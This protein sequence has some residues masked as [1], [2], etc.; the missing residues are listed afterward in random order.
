M[1]R[2]ATEYVEHSRLYQFRLWGWDKCYLILYLIE[3]TAR[4]REYTLHPLAFQ[5]STSALVAT[6]HVI[7]LVIIQRVV[8]S[9]AVT[10]ATPLAPIWFL[11]NV[12]HNKLNS[13]PLDK[14]T[15]ISQ[16]IISDAY[17]WMK[18]FVFCLKFH[19]SLFLRVPLT[20]TSIGLDNGLTPNRRQAIIW[21]NADSIHWRIYAALGRDGFITGLEKISMAQRK[22]VV[23]PVWL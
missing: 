20:I 22:T 12:S 9:V 14:L 5:I 6:T 15:A 18:S 8:L 1:R 19:R 21:T 10:L 2:R 23:T 11:V 7:W 17:S 3:M 16:T 13:S 4:W